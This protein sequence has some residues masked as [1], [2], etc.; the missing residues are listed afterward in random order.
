MRCVHKR[1]DLVFRLT[2]LCYQME[3]SFWFLSIQVPRNCSIKG[4]PAWN[5]ASGTDRSKFHPPWVPKQGSEEAR[6]RKSFVL[7]FTVGAVIRYP[8]S[9]KATKDVF[10]ALIINCRLERIWDGQY[11]WSRRLNT[12]WCKELSNIFSQTS[13]SSQSEGNALKM[14]SALIWGP[15]IVFRANETS[16]C[17]SEGKSSHLFTPWHTR[18][19]SYFTFQSL[20]CWT[21]Q[22]N[23]PSILSQVRKLRKI[24]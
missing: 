9:C 16:C 3:K 22:T 5:Q 4:R 23:F 8:R 6:K 18:Y 10:D 19:V 11:S 21:Q 17:K 13:R 12:P 1:R 2:M 15:S 24:V 14:V 7:P 20:K